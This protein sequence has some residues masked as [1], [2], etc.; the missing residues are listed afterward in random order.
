MTRVVSV[1]A[2]LAVAG[3]AAAQPVGAINP[4]VVTARIENGSLV[5]ATTQLLPVQ[6]PVVVTVVVNGRPTAETRTVTELTRVTSERSEA[7]K[8]LKAADGAGRAIN[9]ERLAERLREEATVVLHVGR[10]P[11]AFRRAFRDE[12]ILI[13]LPGPAAPPRQ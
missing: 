9:A 7:V 3:S 12:T 1:V 2:L 8:N 11:D 5:W 6:K 10:L 4:Q 13:E